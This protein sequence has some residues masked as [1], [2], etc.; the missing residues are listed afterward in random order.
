[1]RFWDASA[2]VPL[3]VDEPESA[4]VSPLLAEDEDMAVWWA[5]HIECVSAIERKQREGE[6][7]WNEASACV[8]VLHD[9]SISWSEIQPSLSL[10]TLAESFL[11]LYPLRAADACQLAAALRWSGG[12]PTGREFV[13]LNGNLR[14][15]ATTEGFSVLPERAAA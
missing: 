2:V 11:A 9:L 14:E 8:R 10:R 1:M 13:S 6:L 4:T 3:L 5:T 12:N 15:A 7:D